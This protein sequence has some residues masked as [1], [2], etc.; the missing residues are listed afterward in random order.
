MIR[1]VTIG[2]PTRIRIVVLTLFL[3]PVSER[4]RPYTA[5]A[6]GYV[7]LMAAALPIC[8]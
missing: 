1:A 7:F 2:V 3:L 8:W 5:I 6:A 4:S